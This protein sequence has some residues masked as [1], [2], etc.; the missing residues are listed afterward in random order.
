V[1]ERPSEAA[2]IIELAAAL[3]GD[4]DAAIAWFKYQPIVG[5]GG[6]TAEQL[7]GEGHADAVLWHLDT[8]EA[9]GVA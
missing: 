8:L 9:G 2:R 3:S 1:G 7:V 6:K 5:F 4:E